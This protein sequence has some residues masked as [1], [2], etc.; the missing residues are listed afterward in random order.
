MVFRLPRALR[1]SFAG[2]GALPAGCSVRWNRDGDGKRPKHTGGI[3][4]VRQAGI[5][6]RGRP[7]IADALRFP[8]TNTPFSCP[9]RPLRVN[10]EYRSSSSDITASDGNETGNTLPVAA[11]FCSP[12]PLR[13]VR[14]FLGAAT[15]AP[16]FRIAVCKG[17]P[18]SLP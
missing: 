9:Y 12:A 5:P 1:A 3:P 13:L 4:S 11:A 15:A 2:A 8:V 10:L 7:A 17:I 16:L 18:C 14:F 6:F